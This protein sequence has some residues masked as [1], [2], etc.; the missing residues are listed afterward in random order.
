[1]N[2]AFSARLAKLEEQ[3]SANPQIVTAS[4]PRGR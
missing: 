3:A 1:M 4:V 2:N